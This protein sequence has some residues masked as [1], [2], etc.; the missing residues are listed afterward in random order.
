M[1]QRKT[2]VTDRFMWVWR[3]AEKFR[4]SLLTH[5]PIETNA[6][7]WVRWLAMPDTTEWRIPKGYQFTNRLHANKGQGRKLSLTFS[8]DELLHRPLRDLFWILKWECD[9]R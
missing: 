7:L 2:L 6:Y 5:P 1:I 9:D 4:T 3:K 8:Q